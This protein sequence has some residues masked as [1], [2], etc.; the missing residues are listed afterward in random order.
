[1]KYLNFITVLVL[2]M[3]MFSSVSFSQTSGEKSKEAE[4]SETYTPGVFVDK[5][6]DGVCD[7]HKYHKEGENYTDENNDGICDYYSEHHKDGKGKAYFHHGHRN[8][9]GHKH[10]NGHGYRHGRGHGHGC[11][12][13]NSNSK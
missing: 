13:N 10:G 11:H 3:L 1:M 12:Y 9:K 4:E 7:N 2:A 8:G 6:N 5:D